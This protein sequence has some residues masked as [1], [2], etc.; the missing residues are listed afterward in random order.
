MTLWYQGTALSAT[1]PFF[2]FFS[3]QAQVFDPYSFLFSTFYSQF[4]NYLFLTG[5]SRYPPHLPS[6]LTIHTTTGNKV[7]CILQCWENTKHWLALVC[8]MRF[9][10][11]IC[12]S[13]LKLDVV[14][15]TPLE[16]QCALASCQSTNIN[17]HCHT[18]PA[19][20]LKPNCFAMHQLLKAG[21]W[22]SPFDADVGSS[23]SSLCHRRQK[24]LLIQFHG[25]TLQPFLAR[26]A[27]YQHN[28]SG[29][30]KSSDLCVLPSF[31]TGHI[32]IP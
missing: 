29:W 5:K 22:S 19:D 17:H 7:L 30:W 23:E 25:E 2:F 3:F 1:F 14:S 4:R 27:C 21:A 6:S 18:R 24:R 13:F 15:S 32:S 26:H 8:T 31:A 12:K 9:Y 16:A 11:N 28:C 10:I 20:M